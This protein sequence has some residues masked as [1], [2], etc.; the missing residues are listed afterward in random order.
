M[1]AGA[2]FMGLSGVLALP[3]LAQRCA[4]VMGSH[5]VISSRFTTWGYYHRG[6]YPLDA[7]RM[8]SAVRDTMA[9]ALARAADM[10]V[11]FVLESG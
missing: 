8:L 10:G 9:A 4:A 6:L 5:I 7:D 11:T 3:R 2:E 1:Q